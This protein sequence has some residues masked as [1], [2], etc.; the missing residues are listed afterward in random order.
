MTVSTWLQ[1]EFE[2]YCSDVEHTAAWGGQLE[3]SASEFCCPSISFS[4][5]LLVPVCFSA[6]SFDTSTAAARR[7]RSGQLDRHKDRRGV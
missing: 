5:N 6:A 2:K 7:S 4:S 3:V 1:D